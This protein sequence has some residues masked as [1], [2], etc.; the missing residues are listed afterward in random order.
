[1]KL[2]LAGSN[3]HKYLEN[4][5]KKSLFVLES[6]FYF[7]EWQ[8]PLIY[9]SK[10]FLLDSGAFTF[11]N[12]KKTKKPDFD[13]YLQN[14]INFINKYDIKLFFELDIDSAVGYKKVL[15]YRKRL[16]YGTNK[17]CIPVWHR[18]RGKDEYY[19]LCENYD[20]IAI[21]GLALK[22]IKRTEHK[23]LNSLCGI[24]KKYNCKVHGLGFTPK[25]AIDY[26]FYSVDSTSWLSGWKYGQIFTFKNNKIFVKEYPTKR[27]IK[28]KEV[29]KFNIQEW[30]KFQ[31]YLYYKGNR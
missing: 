16:E 4:E 31:K 20:Y 19:K 18:S 15:E 21:G 23:A 22:E 24:A 10:D 13:D 26:K 14:Y 27:I 2:F 1:M 25:N 9:S 28:G 29:H 12:S 8:I 7:K 17:K 30:I 5:M 3:A 6:F 11:L